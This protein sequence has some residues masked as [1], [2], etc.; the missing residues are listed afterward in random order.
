MTGLPV[1]RP[2]LHVLASGDMPIQ[3]YPDPILP[4]EPTP[5]TAYDATS[6]AADIELGITVADLDKSN[7]N[8]YK[9]LQDD[10]RERW[11]LWARTDAKLEA[12]MVAI[13][14]SAFDK[15]LN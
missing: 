2:T 9:I 15:Q 7:R 13:D 14:Y 8:L 11:K 6:K 1:T 4:S 12:G 3:H 10:H 5:P